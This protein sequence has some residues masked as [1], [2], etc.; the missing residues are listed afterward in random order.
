[1]TPN[2]VGGNEVEG[3]GFMF[4]AI[5]VN[6]EVVLARPADVERAKRVFQKVE[7]NCLVSKSMSTAVTIR[8]KIT[9]TG[10]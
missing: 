8:S 1:M 5:E 4:T 9:S 3:Q 2:N 7:R 10:D 6:A